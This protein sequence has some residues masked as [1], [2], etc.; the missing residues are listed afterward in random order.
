V[1]TYV[2]AALKKKHA[3][4]AEDSKFTGTVIGKPLDTIAEIQVE[5]GAVA[6]INEWIMQRSSFPT[7]GEEASSHG[8]GSP[9]PSS[10]LSSVGSKLDDDMDLS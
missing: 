7:E 1:L 5:G 4:T 2:S 6:S 8:R 9:T 3:K 10:G